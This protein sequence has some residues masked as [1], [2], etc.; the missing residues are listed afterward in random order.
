M[1]STVATRSGCPG[2]LNVIRNRPAGS[3]S[4]RAVTP[5]A[6]IVA[7][8]KSPFTNAGVASAVIVR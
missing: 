4:M 6:T 8:P 3:R 1:R 7:P 5:A 2:R